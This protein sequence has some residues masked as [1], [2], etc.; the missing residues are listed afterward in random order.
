MAIAAIVN[1]TARKSAGAITWTTSRMRKNVEPQIAV[2]AISRSVAR[3]R[4]RTAVTGAG[5]QTTV[6]VMVEPFGASVPP[7]TDWSLTVPKNPPNARSTFTL[8]PRACRI[9]VAGCSCWPMTLGTATISGPLDTSRVT[10]SPWNRVPV[11]GD[12]LITDPLG[13]VALKSRLV[14]STLR[15]AWVSAATACATGWPVQSAIRIGWRPLLITRSTGVARLSEVSAGGDVVMT[16]PAGTVSLNPWLTAPTLS[17]EAIN[18]CSASACVRPMSWGT[19]YRS[20]PCDTVRVTVVPRLT[21][22]PA[23]GS[24]ARTTPAWTFSLNDL[25]TLASR[26]ARVSAFSAIRLVEPT[27]LGTAVLAPGPAAKK[28][29]PAATATSTSVMTTTGQVRPRSLATEG[30]RQR[31]P[32]G[33]TPGT[34]DIN[35]SGTTAVRESMMVG[36]AGS[37]PPPGRL[38]S[39]AGDSP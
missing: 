29:S 39:S 37:E 6:N 18:R 32:E 16:W 20:G 2:M 8:K 5:S 27:T 25:T 7:S 36:F 31:R 19:A 21:S 28:S 11:G 15:L 33:P 35:A 22:R 4:E 34:G 23:G 24:P 17:R 26:W 9:A 1:R 3:L 10:R 13:T 14:L 12:W 30:H 38:S